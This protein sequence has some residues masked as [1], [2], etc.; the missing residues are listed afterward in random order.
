M[1]VAIKEKRPHARG[2]VYDARVGKEEVSVLLTFHS[3]ERAERWRLTERQVVEAVLCPEEVLR[4]IADGSSRIVA[5][6]GD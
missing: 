5:A 1:K 2:Y 6:G 4:G 3:L